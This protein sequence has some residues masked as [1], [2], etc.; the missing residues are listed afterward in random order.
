MDSYFSALLSEP[1]KEQAEPPAT[2]PVF[3]EPVEQQGKLAELL[4]NVEPKVAA[5]KPVETS[6]GASAAHSVVKAPVPPSPPQWQNI[7]TEREFQ[8]LFFVVSGVT[9]AVPLTELG[10]IHQLAKI[11]TLFGKPDR[12]AGVMTSVRA[13][14]MWWTLHAGSCRVKS[15]KSLINIS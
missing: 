2:V 15:Q 8:A 6:N 14:S 3:A 1:A 12:F 10:G 13:S 4:A 5:P 7:V 11:N 9:F